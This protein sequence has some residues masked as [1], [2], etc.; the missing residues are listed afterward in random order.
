MKGY[1]SRI[2]IEVLGK[3]KE[4]AEE[5]L[6]L[7]ITK[8]REEEGVRVLSTKVFDSKEMDSTLWSTFADIEFQVDTL[9]KVLDVCYDYTPSMI[10]ILEPAGAEVDMGDMAELLNDFLT[11]IHR[12]SMVLKKLKAENIY[13][14]KKIK[15][16]IK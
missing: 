6:Q 1:T 10:E 3:P 5:M 8:L 11:R 14:M 16:E 9:K 15:G 4:Y 12:Y 7:S 2:T 13:M